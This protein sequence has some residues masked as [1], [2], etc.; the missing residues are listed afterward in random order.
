MSSLI[1]QLSHIIHPHSD[2]QRKAQ[3][4]PAPILEV[5]DGALE[6]LLAVRTVRSTL[7]TAAMLTPPLQTSNVQTSV[8]EIDETAPVAPDALVEPKEDET[9]STSALGKTYLLAVDM[10]SG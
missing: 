6:L 9:P 10:P 8:Q 2:S 4:V 3:E 5:K 7:A 1:S